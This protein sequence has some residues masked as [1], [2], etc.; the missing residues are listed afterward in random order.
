[1]ADT[2]G[3]VA[4]AAGTDEVLR[5]PA[6]GAHLLNDRERGRLARFRREQGRRDFLAAHVLVRFC[7]GRLLGIAPAEVSFAQ[8][9]PT[10]HGSD[11]GR[12]LLAGRPDVH[13]SLSHTDGV[14]AAAAGRVPVGIDVERL[15]RTHGPGAM[16]RALTA[17]ERALVTAAA[18]PGRAF[19]RQWVRKE[20]LIKIGRTDL[21]ALGRLDLSGL[22]LGDRADGAPLRF[23]D[24]YVTDLTDSRLGALVAAVGTEPVRLDAALPSAALSP[25]GPVL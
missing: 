8:H 15:G 5:H 7:A 25:P 20:A 3:P 1:M 23:E 17:A 16:D 14:V 4:V 18:D 2:G 22:P 11:H 21:D 10:C 9:C 6:A 24:L 13:L 12:P 19:L